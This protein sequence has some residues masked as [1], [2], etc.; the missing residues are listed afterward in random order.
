MDMQGGVAIVTG[1]SSGVGAACAARLAER[2]A[3]LIINYASNRDGA[4]ATREA[5]EAFGVETRI[6]Q[7]DVAS[8][9]DC[10]RMVQVAEDAWGRVDAL[11]NNAGTTVFCPHDDLEGLSADDFQRIYAVNTIGAYQMSRAVA[12]VMRRGGRGSIVMVAS[13]AGVMGVGSSIAYAASKGAMLT[14]TKSLARVLGPEIRVNAVCPGFIQG[15]WLRKGMGDAA[16][17]AAKGFL[18]KATPLGR[19]AT[20]D[21]V[22]D[23]ILAFAE[24]MDLVTGE[25][26]IFDGGAHLSGM[27]VRR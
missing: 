2:G 10:R 14:L 13:I 3:H 27:P 5:C 15:D 12:P 19:T 24:G 1:S 18:E 26:L 11:V 16:Y 4:E 21:T 8:D 25:T 17:D 9:E 23:A 7:A 6:V 22:A 20:A